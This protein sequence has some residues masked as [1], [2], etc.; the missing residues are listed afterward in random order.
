MYV[1]SLCKE[2]VLR[3]YC[4]DASRVAGFRWRASRY[5][6]TVR[7]PPARR[8]AGRGK[9]RLERTVAR[10]LQGAAGRRE[11]ARSNSRRDRCPDRCPAGLSTA[12][13]VRRD[14]QAPRRN[15]QQ[16]PARVLRHSQRRHSGQSARLDSRLLARPHADDLL[17]SQ[18]LRKR[19]DRPLAN[20]AAATPA[21]ASCSS[22]AAGANAGRN[23]RR[24]SNAG[25]EP[26]APDACA[27]HQLLASVCDP[28][29][30]HRGMCSRRPSGTET[31]LRIRPGPWR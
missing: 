5:V 15:D 26:A 28:D 29:L 16:G 7:H 9:R 18:R 12:I 31:L 13:R 23:G 14:P 4:R 25:A 1:A 6:G 17:H 3:P 27:E 19:L 2:L 20:P 21:A 30:H 22:A 10:P 11:D 24:R 8:S